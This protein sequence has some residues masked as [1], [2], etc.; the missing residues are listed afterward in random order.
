MTL[1]KYGRGYILK[2]DEEHPDYGV[3]YYPSQSNCRAWWQ[4]SNKG[5]FVQRE[6]KNYFLE[7]GAVFIHHHS[8]HKKRQRKRNKRQRY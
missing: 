8:Q 5:W 3:K 4:D 7:R 6:N 2:V 1:E